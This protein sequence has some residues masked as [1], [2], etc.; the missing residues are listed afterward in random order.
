MAELIKTL[1]Q[2]EDIKSAYLHAQ[3]K[4]DFI[5][6][7]CGGAGCVSSNCQVIQDT[8]VA[9]AEKA[10]IG[11]RVLVYQTGCMGTCAVGPVMLVT[12][13]NIFYTELTPAKVQEIVKDA[14][15]RRQGADA[16]HL[17]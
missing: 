11:S 9:E 3:E 17:L 16:V 7:V 12:P 6:Y 5:V 8:L 1:R 2:L 10:G 15:G 13:G 14:S 4:Y